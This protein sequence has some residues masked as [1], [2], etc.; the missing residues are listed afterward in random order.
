MFNILLIDVFLL[1]CGRI[2]YKDKLKINV[3]VKTI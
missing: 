1:H 2:L 3:E